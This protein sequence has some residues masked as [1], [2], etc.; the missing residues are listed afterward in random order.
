MHEIYNYLTKHFCDY[1]SIQELCV[2]KFAARAN[3]DKRYSLAESPMSENAATGTDWEDPPTKDL[4]R[5]T[6]DV[7]NENV[8]R[9]D[10]HTSAEALVKGTSAESAGTSVLLESA[11]HETQ[12]RPQNSLQATLWR[13]P[14]ED[15]PSK[16]EQEV[17][18]SLVTAERMNGMVQS[19]KPR[20][21]VADVDRMALLGRDLAERACGVDKGGRKVADVDRK[22]VLG[23]ELVE[24]VHVVNEGTK[25]EHERQS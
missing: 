5:G 12:D 9:K 10:P 13:L 19:A 24:R 15:E 25:M 11:P 23:R 17:V 18:E 16:C 21:M 6:E 1:D 2:K 7:N 8:R 22:A 14:I 20:K 3:E 4:N